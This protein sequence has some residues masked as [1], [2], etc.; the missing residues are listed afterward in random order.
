MTSLKLLSHPNDSIGYSSLLTVIWRDLWLWNSLRGKRQLCMVNKWWNTSRSSCMIIMVLVVIIAISMLKM[1]LIL[2]AIIWCD[3][4]SIELVSIRSIDH[5]LIWLPWSQS[6][7]SS[8]SLATASSSCLV[9][10]PC[11]NLI[12][13]MSHPYNWVIHQIPEWLSQEPRHPKYLDHL[14][15]SG[16]HKRYDTMH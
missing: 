14:R 10:I 15:V 6:R 5:L 12:L 11:S 7:S 2:S 3:S 1:N 8:P 16:H 13:T 4:P 9:A